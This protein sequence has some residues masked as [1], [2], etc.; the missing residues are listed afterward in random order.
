MMGT[1]SLPV[2]L[3][4]VV[5]LLHRKLGM[6]RNLL[7]PLHRRLGTASLPVPLPLVVVLLHHSSGT[8][9]S[10]RGPLHHKQ[11][12]LSPMVLLDPLPVVLLPLRVS[13]S[14]SS[15]RLQEGSQL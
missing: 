9:L 8:P 12:R 5:V 15:S 2:P 4:L 1:A 13:S 10:R 7:G 3:P 14:S 6:L 11:D